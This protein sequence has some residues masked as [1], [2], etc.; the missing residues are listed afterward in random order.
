MIARK[1]FFTEKKQA[2]YECYQTH[3]YQVKLFLEVIT[4]VYYMRSGNFLGI[5][6]SSPNSLL[7]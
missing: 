1:S 7:V 4:N 5:E 3:F 6:L 2:L